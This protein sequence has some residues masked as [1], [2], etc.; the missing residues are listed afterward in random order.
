MYIIL[1]S[2]ILTFLYIS[3]YQCRVL[4]PFYLFLFCINSRS[5]SNTFN[6]I[7]CKVLFTH[8]IFIDYF[9]KEHET[10]PLTFPISCNELFKIV[11]F[12]IIL[13]LYSTQENLG[14]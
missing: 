12:D 8:L 3:N 7:S 13:N 5:F 11:Y 14:R 10:I 6:G 4:E 2:D 1:P 9:L